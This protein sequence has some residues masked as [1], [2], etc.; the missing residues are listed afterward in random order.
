MHLEEFKST[1]KHIKVINTMKPI[2][3]MDAL[4]SSLKLEVDE[5]SKSKWML[6]NLAL[7]LIMIFFIQ[8]G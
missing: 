6:V 4:I 3:N 5:G 7:F 1:W 8:G 2:G